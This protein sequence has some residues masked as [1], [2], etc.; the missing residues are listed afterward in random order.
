MAS[1]LQALRNYVTAEGSQN[2]AEST[3]RLVVTHSNLKATFM[4]IRLDRH[5]SCAAVAALCRRAPIAV[6]RLAPTLHETNP[7]RRPSQMTIDSVKRKLCF[8]T[9]TSPSAM[10]LHLRDDRGAPVAA[11]AD[12]ARKLGFYSP[13]DGWA[14]HVVDND[15]TSASANGWLEDTS[16]VEKYVMSDAAYEA[17]DNTYRKYKA[18]QLRKDPSWTLEKEMAARRARGAGGAAAAA[19]AAAAAPPRAKVEDEEH[20]AGAAAALEVSA[21]CEVSSAEGGK[22][23]VVR[24]VGKV[25]GLPLGWWVG[26][27]YDEPVG[28]NDGSVKGRRLFECPPGYGAFVRPSLVAAGDFP[29]FDEF[30][31]SDGDE[32]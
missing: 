5:V 10:E 20:E 2:Q 15:P 27:Q 23:G 30:E 24:F 29:P 1:D 26:V 4:E 11:L 19:A 3:V 13:R 16:K 6:D 21:R 17:R 22:R 28:R 18:E 14:L 32:I 8:H 7:R 9:G 25:E 31:F 12:G